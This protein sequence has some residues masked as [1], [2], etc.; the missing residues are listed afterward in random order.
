MQALELKVPPVALVL[1]IALAMWGGSLVS[2]PIE[3]PII[4]RAI[5]TAVL[6]VVGASV[7]L[8]G[9]VSFRRARTTVNPTMPNTTS[10][11]VSSGIY[12]I[13]RNPMYL[14]FLL[15]LV[16]WT[17]FLSNTL[18]IIGPFAFVFYMNTFQISPEE[19]ALSEIFGAEF[20]AYKTAVRRWL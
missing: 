2:P 10:T 11:L 12:A 19:R 18:A 14:G 13:T 16:G 7:S 9:V 6:V 8:A 4:A 17:V 15:I 3:L 1:V 20:S 5:A